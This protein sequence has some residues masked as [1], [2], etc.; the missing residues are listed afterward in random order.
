MDIPLEALTTFSY[1]GKV[2]V[3][4]QEFVAR[5][6]GDAKVLT[7]L[8]KAKFASHSSLSSVETA[9]DKPKRKYKRRDLT[10]ESE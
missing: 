10:A 7:L 8:R 4:G 1:D 5:S 6:H 2:V 3:R 9:D